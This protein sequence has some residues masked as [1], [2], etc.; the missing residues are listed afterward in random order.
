MNYN[1]DGLKWNDYNEIDHYR[2]DYIE[3]GFNN[4]KEKNC[5]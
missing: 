1:E 4:F 5:G 2:V 3:N